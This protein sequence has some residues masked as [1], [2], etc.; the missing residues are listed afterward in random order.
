MD[1]EFARNGFKLSGPLLGMLRIDGDAKLQGIAFQLVDAEY[2]P[3]R[4]GAQRRLGV[5]AKHGKIDG[6]RGSS[7]IE[8]KEPFQAELRQPAAK[9]IVGLGRRVDLPGYF[10]VSERDPRTDRFE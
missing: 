8:A 10:L 2:G 9:G 1:D 6:L 3:G 4:G 7:W 5:F